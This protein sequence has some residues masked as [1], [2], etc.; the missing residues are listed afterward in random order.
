MCV[1]RGVIMRFRA[2]F[3]TI[4]A[5]LLMQHKRQLGFKT[6]TQ[7]VVFGNGGSKGEGHDVVFVVRDMPIAR[8]GRFCNIWDTAGNESLAVS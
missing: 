4:K 5:H 3:T 6:I 2:N 7:A 8:L 1:V